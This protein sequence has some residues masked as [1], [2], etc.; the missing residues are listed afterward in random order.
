MLRC[1]CI[2]FRESYFLFAKVTN[3]TDFVTLASRKRLPEYD[4]NASKHVGV[5][6]I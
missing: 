4:A 2:I 6:T 3:R 5:L 1:I